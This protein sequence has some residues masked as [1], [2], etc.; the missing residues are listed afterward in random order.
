MKVHRIKLQTRPIAQKV[1]IL[2]KWIFVEKVIIWR[3]AVSKNLFTSIIVGTFGIDNSMFWDLIFFEWTS[4][5]GSPFEVIMKNLP[6]S[7]TLTLH[8]EGSAADNLAVGL[9]LCSASMRQWNALRSEYFSAENNHWN[10]RNRKNR[11][12]WHNLKKWHN[13]E[14]IREVRID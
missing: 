1:Y 7:S 14:G 8:C 2:K 5:S 13:S 4:W 9:E 6:T 12:K 3:G 10:K 11:K